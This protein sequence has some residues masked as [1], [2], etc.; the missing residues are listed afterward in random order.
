MKRYIRTSWSTPRKSKS[1]KKKKKS[2]GG[3]DSSTAFLRRGGGLLFICG[4]EARWQDGNLE[5][6]SRFSGFSRYQYMSH[7]T[8]QFGRTPYPTNRHVQNRH[9]RPFRDSG[10]LL[11]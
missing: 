2:T 7:V 4:V 1:T 9:E 3:L 8:R 10:D 5:V 11:E 6:D